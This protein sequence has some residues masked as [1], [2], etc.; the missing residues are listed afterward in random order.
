MEKHAV[1]VEVLRPVDFDI[2][3]GVYPDMTEH[4]WKHDEWPSLQDK[5]MATNILVVCADLA[6]RQ[7]IRVQQGN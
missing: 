7:I 2:A 1:E 3:Y 5:V 6:G 4:G